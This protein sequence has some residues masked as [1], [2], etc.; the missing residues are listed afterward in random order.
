MA[1]APKGIHTADWHK[2]L[3]AAFQTA[4]PVGQPLYVADLA[5]ALELSERTIFRYLRRM[6]SEGIRIIGS[7]G[8][9]GGIMRKS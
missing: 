6:K 3:Y 2:K 8:A 1:Q 9:G 4:L 7:K 5:A